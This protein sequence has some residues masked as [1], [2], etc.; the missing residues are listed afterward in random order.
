MIAN[1]SRSLDH[2]HNGLLTLPYSNRNNNHKIALNYKNQALVVSH[3]EEMLHA[4]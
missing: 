2:H 1:S 4:A 3:Q